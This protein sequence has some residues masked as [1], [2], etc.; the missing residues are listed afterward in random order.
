MVSVIFSDVCMLFE[1]RR[2]DTKPK[3]KTICVNFL[4]LIVIDLNRPQH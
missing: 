1:Q 3:S 2:T 4:Q